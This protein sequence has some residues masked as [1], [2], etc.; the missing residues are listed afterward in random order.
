MAD[1]LDL[2]NLS[3][4]LNT[5]FRKFKQ[6]LKSELQYGFVGESGP[7]SMESRCTL[8][9]G[10]VD[11]LL[12]GNVQAGDFIRQFNASD[13][14]TFNPVNNDV[15]VGANILKMRKFKGDL[16]FVDDKINT[17][18]LMWQAKMEA[19]NQGKSDEKEMAFVEYLF[20]N[21]II[22]SALRSL[23]KASYQA[24]WNAN[25]AGWTSGAPLYASAN[26]L[27]GMESLLYTAINNS[28]ITP[29]AYNSSNNV[30]TAVLRTSWSC[31]ARIS[32]RS[33]SALTGPAQGSVV[34]CLS[35][36]ERH[37]P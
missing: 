21:V 14:N 8:I 2:S 35:I 3:S 12:L 26:I 6:G 29:H 27:D 10:V 9:P 31:S 30:V 17:T 15:N 5:Y 24:V 7:M 19:I 16:L 18:F 32:I 20:M 28:I 4:D 33:G 25:G 1:A 34:H 37:L 11:E 13:S 23:R 36:A 22:K